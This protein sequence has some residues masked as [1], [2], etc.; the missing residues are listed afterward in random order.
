M[1]RWK[2]AVFAVSV[3]AVPVAVAA[4]SIG[5]G[6]GTFGPLH[7]N[8]CWGQAPNPDMSTRAFI[9]KYVDD[10]AYQAYGK[11][12]YKQNPGDK[13]IVCNGEVCTTYEMTDSR[14]WN[15]I[16]REAIVGQRPGGGSGTGGGGAGGGGYSGPIGGGSYGGGS[17]YTGSVTVGGPTPEKPSRPTHQD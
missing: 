10:N 11:T 12:F 16:H 2:I 3:C 8:A 1:K 6:S 7:C 14:D 17:G 5:S 15:G 4:W 9:R 13:I